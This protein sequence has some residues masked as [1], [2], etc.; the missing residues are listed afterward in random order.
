MTRGLKFWRRFVEPAFDAAFGPLGRF[1]DKR[2]R[3]ESFKR[4]VICGH[5]RD[6]LRYYESGHY[7]VIEAELMCGGLERLVSPNRTLKWDDVEDALTDEEAARVLRN[8][9]AE[10]DRQKIRWALAG[11]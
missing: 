4:P 5:G 7:V 9:C 2:R 6:A 8:F 10:L 11:V 1:L 3:R